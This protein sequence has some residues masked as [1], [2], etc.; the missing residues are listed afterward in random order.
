[1]DGTGTVGRAFDVSAPLGLWSS[2]MEFNHEETVGLIEAGLSKGKSFIREHKVGQGKIVLLGSMP[3]GE[4]GDHMLRK[5][6]NHYANE[7]NV[8][9]K[10]DVTTGT[11][12]APRQGDGYS[13]WF[14]INMDGNGGSVTIPRNGI[15]L[16]T[17]NPVPQGQVEFGRFEFKIIQFD[18]NE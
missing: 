12:V 4:Q 8:K 9:I 7:A 15:D 18:G 6:I 14:I 13:V 10:T 17:K 5:L 3:V 16:L 1:M 2:V 11:I